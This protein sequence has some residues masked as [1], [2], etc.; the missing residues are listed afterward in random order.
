MAVARAAVERVAARAAGS[1]VERA[2]AK[3]AA[4]RR[5]RRGW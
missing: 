5:W 4:E 3:A 1:A 2:A